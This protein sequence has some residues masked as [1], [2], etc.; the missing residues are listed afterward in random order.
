M[1][2]TSPAGL[3]DSAGKATPGSFP[4]RNCG[5][6]AGGGGSGLAEYLEAQV[7]LDRLFL[8]SDP[9]QL[10]V[11]LFEGVHASCAWT[12]R[13]PLGLTIFRPFWLLRFF[14]GLTAMLH[15]QYT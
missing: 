1:H 12:I 7:G 6:A 15:L 10:G 8:V 14:G 2:Q 11:T 13:P 3:L 4:P 5:T 9:W